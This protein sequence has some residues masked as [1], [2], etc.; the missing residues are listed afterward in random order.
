[1]P[2]AP[3]N[4]L[5]CVYLA[6]ESTEISSGAGEHDAHELFIA[7]LNGVHSALMSVGREHSSRTERIPMYPHGDQAHGYAASRSG[8]ASNASDDGQDNGVAPAFRY[9]SDILC[10]CV[11]HRTFAGVLQSD[12]TCQRCSW[13]SSTHDP[14]L[15]LSLDI[16]NVRGRGMSIIDLDSDAK[17]KGK[18]HKDKDDKERRDRLMRDSSGL[19]DDQSLVECLR[20][21]CAIE[22][23]AQSDYSCTQCGVPSQAVKQL[24]ICRL[25]PVLCIQLKRFE[26]NTTAGA[27]IETRVKFPL[28]LDM[29]E[30]YTN[31]MREDLDVKM[32][33]ECYL[34][35]LFSV[36]VH[37]GRLNTGHYYCYIKW[38]D[39]WYIAN[40]DAMRPARLEDVL[41]CRAYQ[42][43]YRRRALQNV[44]AEA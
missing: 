2:F 9:T 39:G 18:K 38:R 22:K 26:H 10:P 31:S 24:S 43:C 30:Y 41:T 15:D 6:R 32:D 16:R 5:F 20:R 11:V 3:T 42:L 35:D 1:M 33:P 7:A 17:K 4:F 40:D 34:Y 12:V 13:T 36:V 44:R 28:T 23:L 29:R 8:T 19:D 27:K 25:P 37:E 14:F 21:Y